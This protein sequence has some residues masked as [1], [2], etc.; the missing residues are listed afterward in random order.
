M[1]LK[2]GKVETAAVWSKEHKYI[3]GILAEKEMFPQSLSTT[4]Q[5]YIYT[6]DYF[7]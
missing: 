3:A 6:D 7:D 1:S 2:G 4:I 5:L